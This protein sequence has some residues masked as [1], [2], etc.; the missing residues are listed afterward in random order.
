MS[1]FSVEVSLHNTDPLIR[2]ISWV[3]NKHYSAIY[4]LLKLTLN[5]ALP[6]MLDKVIVF[7]TDITVAADIAELWALFSKFGP[8]QYFGLVEN[9]SDWYLGKIWKNHRPWPAL[10]RGFNSGV[11][12]VRLSVLRSSNWSQLWKLVAEKYLTTLLAAQLADQDILNAV[13]KNQPEI[14]Y[15]LPCQWNVQLSD[16]TRSELCYLELTDIKAIHWNS[17][18]K[19]KVRNKHIEFFRSL[20]LTFLEYD[21]NLLRRELFGCNGTGS[22][23]SNNLIEQINEDDECYEFRRARQTNYRTHLFYIAPKSGLKN[24]NSRLAGENND[25]HALVLDGVESVDVTLVATLSMDRLQ[26]VEQLLTHWDGECPRTVSHNPLV[27]LLFIYC[28]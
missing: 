10:G 7:D 12:L 18:K 17:P 20:H 13:I 21:G 19:L 24:T 28:Y 5:K 2:D 16:N 25:I 8:K 11:M 6:P 27:D 23:Q 15:T 26:M 22:T 1:Y 14:V 4:G 9:Q 3:P